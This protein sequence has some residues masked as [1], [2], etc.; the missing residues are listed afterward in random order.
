MNV[1]AIQLTSGKLSGVQWILLVEILRL[2]LLEIFSDYKTMHIIL[3]I[4]YTGK[5]NESNKRNPI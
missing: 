4:E 2:N 1:L 5:I 3:Y